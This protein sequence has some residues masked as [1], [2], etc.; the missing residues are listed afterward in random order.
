MDAP[1]AMSMIVPRGARSQAMLFVYCAGHPR[2]DAVC[3]SVTSNNSL[4]LRTTA[5][6]FGISVLGIGV[7]LTLAFVYNRTIK[8][9]EGLESA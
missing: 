5:G 4:Q 1:G 8:R 2:C 7:L 6:G 9:L 3:V